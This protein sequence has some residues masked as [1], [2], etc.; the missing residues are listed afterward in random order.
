MIVFPYKHI[1]QFIVLYRK[2]QENLIS[3]TIISMGFFWGGGIFSQCFKS[4][5]N[6]NLN[7]LKIKSNF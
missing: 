4:R 3:Q 1:K 6:I 5:M 7:S 2:Y